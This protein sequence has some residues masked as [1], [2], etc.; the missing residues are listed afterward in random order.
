MG[1]E[2]VKIDAGTV[3]KEVIL[4]LDT[5]AYADADVLADTQEIA[6]MCPVGGTGF[7]HSLVVL[8]K[9]D[10]GEALDIVL[11]RTNVSI[12]TE[13]SAISVSDAN[14]DE[15]VGAVECAAD[16]YIDLAGSQ[17]VVKGSLGIAFQAV[18][19]SMFVAA[20]SRGTGTYAAAGIT[21]KL[22]FLLDELDD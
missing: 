22:G 3:Y 16:D 8:D 1:Q 21:L 20:V 11:L 4:S 5:G 17:I 14:A 7:W 18:N 19:T 6:N 2:K 10:Q 13:N 12:G 15:I 9:S